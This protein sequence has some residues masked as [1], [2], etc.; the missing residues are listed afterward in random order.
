M[1]RGDLSV[2]ANSGASAAKRGGRPWG[3]RALPLVCPGKSA[4]TVLAGELEIITLQG[5][6]IDA[7]L[8]AAPSS[9]K[10]KTGVTPILWTV[11]RASLW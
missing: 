11:I 4:P 5:T 1:L 7:T 3:W 2:L 9:T 6:I 8:I 10:N